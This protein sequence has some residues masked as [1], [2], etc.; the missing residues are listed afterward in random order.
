[1]NGVGPEPGQGQPP[2]LGPAASPPPPIGPAIA[3]R[4]AMGLGTLREPPLNPAG[5]P[6]NPSWVAKAVPRVLGVIA[7]IASALAIVAFSLRRQEHALRLAVEEELLAVTSERDELG[8]RLEQLRQAQERIEATLATVR[9]QLS[10]TTEELTVVRQAKE[11]LGRQVEQR[12][13]D[14]ERLTNE[15]QTLQSER[16]SLVVDATQWRDRHE[17][18]RARVGE[19]EQ[20]KAQLEARVTELTRR[21]MVELDKVVVSE[22]GTMAQP[23]GAEPT[24]QEGHVIVVNREYDFVVMSLGRNHGLEI[25]QEFQIVR[26]NEVLGRVKVEKVYD[27]LSAAAILPESKKDSIREGD[28][29]AAL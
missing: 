20:A 9:G 4:P 29:V 11:E 5:R 26:D 25:G 13:T 16:D 17:A 8:R 27:E 19:L 1:M 15:L 23:A 24:S 28:S 12:R 10:Q 21:P 7:V 6:R 2:E 14:I 18:L 3:S 22:T